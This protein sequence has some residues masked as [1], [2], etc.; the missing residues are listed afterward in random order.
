MTNAEIIWKYFEN[1]KFNPYAI[2]GIMGNMK[3]E[4]NLLPNNLQ[5]T[6]ERSLGMTDEQY[7]KAVD[8]GTYTNFIHDSAGYGL[9]QW[10]YWSLKEGLY[11][12]CKE[13]NKSISDIQCQL[14]CLYQQLTNNKLL[15]SLN[16]ATSVRAASDIFLTKFERPKDQSEKV[17]IMRANYGQEFYNQF[18]GQTVK[19]GTQSKMKYNNTNKPLIC[20][21]T[22]STCY[23]GTGR[24][25]V[26]GVLW[27]CTGANNPWLKRYVQPSDNASDKAELLAKL[28]KNQYGNDWDHV[29]VEAGLNAWIGKLADGTVA[30]VQ[31]M[32]WDYRPWG[33][34]AGSRGSCN[35]GWIQFEI[36]EDALTDKTYFEAAYKEA[37]ELTAYLCKMFSL[38][39]KSSV[40]FNGATVP[41]ILCHQDSY[42]LGLGS[43][44]GDVYNWFNRYGKTMDNVRNDV[45][46]LMASSGSVIPDPTPTP[47]IPTTSCLGKGDEGAEVKQLQENLIK[48]GYSCGS[49]GAD[50]DF[51]NATEQAVIKFQREHGL[52]ADGLVGPLTQSA[53]KTALEKLIPVT[54]TPTPANEMYRIRL[55]WDNPA[56][57]IG[58]YR[59]LDN[60]I[61]ACKQSKGNYKVFNSKG[62]VVYPTGGTSGS[63]TSTTPTEQT[64]PVETVPQ[65][66]T[67]YSG[68]K[69]GSSSKDERG[70]Y[71]GGQAG[72]QTGQEV[73]IQNWYD[74]SWHSVI[75]PKSAAL[76][77]K[78]AA[79]CEKACNNNNIGYDQY[80]RNSLY[81]EALK[82]GMDFS[83]ITTPCECDCS[84]LVSTCCIAAGLSESIFFAGNNM[85]TTYTLI[86]A[87]NKTG[88]FDVLTSSSYT[89][90]KDYLKRGDILL[91]SGHTVVVLS[92][93]DKVGQ[94]VVTQTTAETYRVKVTANTLNVRSGPNTNYAVVTQVKAGDVYTIIEEREGW[95]R[96]KSGAGWIALEY[97]QKI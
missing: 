9:V 87:C 92:N 30:A 17:Q 16:A 42:K 39:P 88:A 1:K 54:P 29:S 56:S 51:G 2:A 40:S 90:S 70:Q 61:Y 48:L 50:G 13:R 93:G 60:A 37:C 5:N 6:Y 12:L 67:Q 96:L 63:S 24:M 46:T 53:I 19:G 15:G 20:M 44:H 10:T 68:V 77:E 69:L 25:A 94:I 45:A 81:R 86:D 66:A 26:K 33:C 80:E 57:Q 91:S 62:E 31:T 82:V 58:A 41:V 79:A 32:P 3:A 75:R 35:N 65:P 73:H 14:D 71:R 59:I 74:G 34:G 97:T 76:A 78:I 7:T 49:W 64:T 84:S 43:N 18:A 89:R 95:G 8:N 85:R 21:M 55:S 36:C 28:G 11:N 4:S 47:V 38:N 27:H 72:D 52:D 23:K 22:N 83:K